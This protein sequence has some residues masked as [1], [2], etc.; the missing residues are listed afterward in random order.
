MS[1]KGKCFDN[2]P[3]KSFSGEEHRSSRKNELVYHQDYQTRHDAI[4]DIIKY[5]ELDYNEE[6]LV[7]HCFAATKGKSCARS[8]TRIQKGLGYKPL[9]KI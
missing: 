2:A 3:I 1:G 4:S 5:T 7:K 8:G 9:R 6:R